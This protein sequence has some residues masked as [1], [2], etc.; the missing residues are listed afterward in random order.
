MKRK[1]Q[2]LTGT[3]ERTYES[4]D[5]YDKHEKRSVSIMSA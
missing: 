4:E 5:Y 3:G 1:I 2:T